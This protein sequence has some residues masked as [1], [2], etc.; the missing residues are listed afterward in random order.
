MNTE[1]KILD[2]LIVKKGKPITAKYI[3]NKLD[4]GYEIVITHIYLLLQ[5]KKISS[6]TLDNKKV[7]WVTS[8]KLRIQCPKCGLDEFF[9]DRRTKYGLPSRSHERAMCDCGYYYPKGT[10]FFDKF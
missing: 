9:S 3:S 6:S 8:K 4:I 7:Y 1:K 2:I 10:K 5:S